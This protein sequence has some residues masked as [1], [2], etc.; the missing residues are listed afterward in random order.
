MRNLNQF[1]TNEFCLKC[2]ECCRFFDVS[3]LPHLLDDDKKAIGKDTI[4]LIQEDGSLKCQFLE[5]ESYKCGI[6]HKRPFECKL[7]PFLVV[8]NGDNLDLTAH[9]GCPYIRDNMASKKFEDYCIY[10]RGKFSDK[11]IVA[12]LRTQKEKFHSYPAVELI[13]IKQT[14]L[15]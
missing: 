4:D 9:L 12:Y 7:Y 3:W 14:L 6:Y 15:G 10:L 1:V 2:R 5:L 11:S 8:K 13:L